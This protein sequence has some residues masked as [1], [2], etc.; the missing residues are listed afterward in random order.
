MDVQKKEETGTIFLSACG[1]TYIL[2]NI[3]SQTAYVTSLYAIFDIR[4]CN[5]FL[6]NLNQEQDFF[7]TGAGSL[8]DAGSLL[9]G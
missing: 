8:L 4:K 3:S 6:N 1:Q 9:A 5:C 2:C 7:W